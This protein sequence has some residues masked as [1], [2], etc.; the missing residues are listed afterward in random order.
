MATTP[1][2][3]AA[4]RVAAAL[5]PAS[6]PDP[7]K[8]FVRRHPGKLPLYLGLLLAKRAPHLPAM[9]RFESRQTALALQQ[10]GHRPTA[11]VA[12]IIPTHRRPR[13]LLAAVESVLVQTVDDLVLCVIDDGAGLPPLPADERLH[14]YSLSRNCGAAGVVRNVGIRASASRYLAFLDD[15]NTWLPDHLEVSLAAHRAGAQLTYT[16]LERHAADGTPIDTLS[17]PFDREAMKESGFIDC[18]TLVIQRTTKVRFTRIRY[19]SGDF[20]FED[21]VLAYRL[22]HS[23]RIEHVPVTTAR[24][25]VN[26]GSYFTDWE[27]NTQMR[28]ARAA[29]SRAAQSR[30]AARAR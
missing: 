17:V 14:T 10:W 1:A 16:A 11:S 18:N 6:L 21:W 28:D 9:W 4:A 15:D 25:L 12:V 13:Q 7:V 8:S 27:A 5:R 30:N 19:R 2:D 26:D 23:M 3:G 22:S 20:P 29:L 24:Y